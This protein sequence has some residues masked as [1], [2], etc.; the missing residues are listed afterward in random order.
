MKPRQLLI[1]L[2]ALIFLVIVIQNS[3]VAQVRILFWTISMSLIILLLLTGLIGFAVGYML[4]RYRAERRD[5]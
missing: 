5:K 3:G 2:L 1:L 4:R